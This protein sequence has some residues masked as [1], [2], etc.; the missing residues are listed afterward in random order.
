MAEVT[1]ECIESV[2]NH[3]GI[4]RKAVIGKNIEEDM[5]VQQALADFLEASHAGHSAFVH[6]AAREEQQRLG[7]WAAGPIK[8]VVVPQEVVITHDV[9]ASIRVFKGG[10]KTHGRASVGRELGNCGTD[11]NALVLAEGEWFVVERAANVTRLQ[12]RFAQNA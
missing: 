11:A 2:R 12:R 5:I 8:I 6:M 1:R 9:P 3:D 4:P 7:V 10:V